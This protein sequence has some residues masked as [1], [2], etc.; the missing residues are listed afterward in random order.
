MTSVDFRPCVI[1]KCLESL[2][3]EASR[4]GAE[5]LNNATKNENYFDTEH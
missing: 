2:S 4:E 5:Q 1:P 3:A